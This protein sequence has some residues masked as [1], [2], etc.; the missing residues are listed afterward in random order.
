VAVAPHT[1]AELA[2]IALEVFRTNHGTLR[3]SLLDPDLQL[4]HRLLGSDSPLQGELLSYLLFDPDFFGEAADLGRRDAKAWLGENPDLWR[5]DGL[6]PDD[7][8]S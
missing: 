5:T 2:D 6:G 7:R 8:P 4:M 1:G 3:R